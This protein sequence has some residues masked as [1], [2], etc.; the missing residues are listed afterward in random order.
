MTETD[1]FICHFYGKSEGEALENC[2]SCAVGACTS[3]HSEPKWDINI[4][5]YAFN[6]RRYIEKGVSCGECHLNVIQG[7]G[8][9]PPKR[10]VECHDEPEIL[11]TKYSSEFIHKNHVTDYKLECYR[12]HSEI[13]HHKGEIPTL[14]HFDSNCGKCHIEEVHL[15]PREMYKGIGG[16]GVPPSPSKMYI[17][18]LDCTAC[19]SGLERGEKAL[20]TVSYDQSAL[21]ARCVGCHGEGYASM[22]RNWQVLV[23][24]AEFETNKGIYTVQSKLYGLDRE[25]VG[26]STLK[27]A[28]QLLNEARR[29]YSFVLLGKAAHNIE[30]A[31]KLLNV[32]R[33]KA[34]EALAMISKDYVPS[35]S[36]LQLSCVN[37]CHSEI[38]KQLLPFGKVSFPHDKHASENGMDCEACHSDRRDHGRTYFKNCSDCHHGESLGRVECEDC[39]ATTS[40]LF[41][42][43][44][45]T[46]VEGI[47][48]LKA[49]IVGC[50]DCHWA[51]E[52]G[53]RSKL[54][55]FRASC[56]RCHE[57]GYGKILDGWLAAEEQLVSHTASK[58]ER[59][60]R[61]MESKQ[62][63]GKKIYVSYKNIFEEAERN[64]NLVEEGKAVHNMDYSEIL[65]ANAGE[66]LDE[67][68]K[69]LSEEK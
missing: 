66:K 48:G 46:G 34:G 63:K 59:V 29:N 31:L 60:R 33:N 50:A 51:T 11:Q 3:C 5:G 53:K 61:V 22:L 39:H 67:V 54:E 57:E 52:Q 47:P 56:I 41:Y 64:F 16:I 21:E 65:M 28:Q 43:R 14:A 6:H 18:N 10:C 7:D 25:K 17:A 27:R 30:Y 55:N 36:D 32:S 62:R 37:L 19:H 44:G 35:N 42:G 9:V 45:G 40:N 20:Y 1:C 69:L 4:A 12:C 15:G 23:A 24:K 58:L 26:S 38:D 2:L 13:I 49:G 8:Q 68:L